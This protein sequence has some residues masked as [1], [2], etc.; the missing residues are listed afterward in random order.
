M[1]ETPVDNSLEI[2]QYV[3]FKWVLFILFLATA[4]KLL[5]NELHINE[6]AGRV[7]TLI[8]DVFRKLWAFITSR[9]VRF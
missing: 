4:Y 3:I 6:F 7:W 1:F 2:W 5:N 8:S 9:N